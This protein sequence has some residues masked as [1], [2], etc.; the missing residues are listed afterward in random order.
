[1]K[2]FFLPLFWWASCSCWC[3][4]DMGKKVSTCGKG[5]FGYSSS[6]F[7]YQPDFV[8]AGPRGRCSL[9]S[10]QRDHWYST[11]LS[12]CQIILKIY[13]LQSITA[14][15]K[16]IWMLPHFSTNSTW[17]QKVNTSPPPPQ[18]LCYN[19]VTSK[20]FLLKIYW[21][22]FICSIVWSLPSPETARS[23]TRPLQKK[24]ETIRFHRSLR[25]SLSLVPTVSY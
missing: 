20:T 7:H 8:A 14:P 3:H 15:R 25:K 9:L 6:V 19:C 11:L 5:G 16:A 12:P 17:F 18:S 2:S 23:L 13:V 1:M 24:A 22:I 21:Y 10:W 4:F